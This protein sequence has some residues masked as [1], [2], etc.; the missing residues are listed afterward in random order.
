MNKFLSFLT[1]IILS[2]FVNSCVTNI[3]NKKIKF[4]TE[5]FVKF[6]HMAY[7]KLCEPDNEN[8]MDDD[9]YRF[10]TGALGSGAIVGISLNGSYV[11]TAAHICNREPSTYDR[12]FK[13]G[14]ERNLVNK[15]FIYDIDEIKYSAEILKY[16]D[17]QDICLTHVWGLFGPV[18]KIS[19]VGPEIGDIVYNMAA[20]AGFMTKR[21]VP[22]FDGF[23][24]GEYREVSIYTLPAVGGS[25]GS[26]IMN[27]KGELI[28][29]VFARH[30]RFHH[31]VLS[32]R[33]IKLRNFI[34]S[35][36]KEHTESVA[37]KHNFPD[38]RGIDIRFTPEVKN[39]F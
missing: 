31:I 30:V 28:G 29:L 1:V 15:F 36:I 2:F 5:S 39:L 4:P 7:Q 32:P 3:T 37:K 6:E 23:Y 33:Y 22:L 34:F 35:A 12:L 10:L 24:S 38:E 18:L 26:P 13:E 9:C 21:M 8:N 14:E 19:S 17:E 16:N 25:S 11:L 27:E 20:P